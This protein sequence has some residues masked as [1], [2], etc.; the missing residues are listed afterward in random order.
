LPWQCCGQWSIDEVMIYCGLVL[1]CIHRT[2]DLDHN[3]AKWR[4]ESVVLFEKVVD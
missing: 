1:N 2:K 4:R 3:V